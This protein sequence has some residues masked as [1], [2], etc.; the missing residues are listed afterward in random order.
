LRLD[1][2]GIKSA[3][4]GSL[5]SNGAWPA[6][7]FGPIHAIGVNEIA[8]GRGQLASH[9]RSIKSKPAAPASSGSARSAPPRASKRSS[10]ASANRYRTASPSCAPICGSLDRKVIGE[11][12]SNAVNIRDR[13]DLVAELND[14]V[15][16]VRAAEGRRLVQDGYQPVKRPAGARSNARKF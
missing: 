11:R 16:D 14:A 9:P 5:W 2:F 6:A 15:S 8:Y 12:A 10:T 3:T 1:A 7:L 13:F 4:R